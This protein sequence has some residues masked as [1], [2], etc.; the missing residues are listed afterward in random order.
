MLEPSES[1]RIPGLC[2]NSDPYTRDCRPCRSFVPCNYYRPR[3]WQ[4]QPLLTF[5]VAGGGF[6]GVETIGGINDFVREAIRSYP[7]LHSNYLRFHL[8]TPDDV[9]LSELKRTLG[10][11]AQRR[12]SSRG[13]EIVTGATVSSFSD[14]VVELRMVK[15][16]LATTVIWSAGTAP[17]DLI[18]KLPLLKRNGRIVVDPYLAVEGRSGIWAVGDC[19]LVTDPHTGGFYPP[20]AQHALKEGRLVARNVV[21]TLYGGDKRKFDS[22]TFGQLAA[23]GHRRGVA[24]ILGLNFSGFVAWWLWRTIYL[25][26]LPRLEKKLRVALDWTLDLFFTKDFARVTP[27]R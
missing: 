4:R 27:P 15:R 7:N 14:G 13:V 22:K 2:R 23:I 5:I 18:A 16:L 24:N 6:A 20:T 25:S 8:V 9:I 12:L 1:S 26:K 19:A 17:N 3:I 21:A 11:Y 10:V